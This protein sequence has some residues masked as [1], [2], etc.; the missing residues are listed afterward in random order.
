MSRQGAAIVLVFVA[1]LCGC[2]AEMSE[3]A[4]I[5][6]ESSSVIILRYKKPYQIQIQRVEIE[7]G[8]SFALYKYSGESTYYDFT[9][10][11]V[12]FDTL[13]TYISDSS[14]LTINLESA[15]SWDVN[16]AKE[17]RG[18]YIFCSCTITDKDI[19]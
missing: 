8:E 14:R 17:G 3:S 9:C 1:M 2:A 16:T 6:N 4:I 7:P 15:S 10:P 19:Q 12:D 11:L 13:Y 5:H 18:G